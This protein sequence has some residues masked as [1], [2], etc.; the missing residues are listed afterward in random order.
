MV[1]VEQ[2]WSEWH[3]LDISLDLGDF[4]SARTIDP[5]S[6]MPRWLNNDSGKEKWRRKREPLN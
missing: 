6:S 3:F 5:R 1:N 2:L 4:M